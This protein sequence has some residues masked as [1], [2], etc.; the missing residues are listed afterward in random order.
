ML[1]MYDIHLQDGLHYDI[2]RVL[3]HPQFIE[4]KIHNIKYDAAILKTYLTIYFS[5]KVTPICLPQ[6]RK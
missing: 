4:K 2:K 1:G 3:F 6:N 5:Y